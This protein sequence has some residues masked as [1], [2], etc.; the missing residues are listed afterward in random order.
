MP[1]NMSTLQNVS[2]NQVQCNNNAQPLH[3]AA[4]RR[5]VTAQREERVRNY[6][7]D[8]ICPGHNMDTNY[9]LEQK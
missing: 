3:F 7:E 4:S 6:R 8:T 9:V 2:G 5:Y 1:G